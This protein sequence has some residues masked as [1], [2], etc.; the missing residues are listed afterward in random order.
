M[1]RVNSWEKLFSNTEYIYEKFSATVFKDFLGQKIVF[2]N[3]NFRQNW[4]FSR[5]FDSVRCR[6]PSRIK[7]RLFPF[8]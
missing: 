3:H 6:D 8:E 7:E 5:V 2:E 1:Y 4:R